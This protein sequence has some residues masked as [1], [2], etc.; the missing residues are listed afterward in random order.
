MPLKVDSIDSPIALQIRL[1]NRATLIKRLADKHLGFAQ[2]RCKL[3]HNKKIGLER[4][5]ASGEYDFVDRTPLVT[6]AADHLAA[7]GYLKPIPKRHSPYRGLSV[8]RD[9]FS[10]V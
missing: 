8:E 6:S 5:H 3:D 7:K 9:Y 10:I 4:T 2:K 1:I